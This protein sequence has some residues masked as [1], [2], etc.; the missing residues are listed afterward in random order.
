MQNLILINYL[1][2]NIDRRHDII[3][4]KKNRMLAI[5]VLYGYGSRKEL[6]EAGADIIVENMQELHKVFDKG[7]FYG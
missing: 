6:Q 2:V 5:G 1:V 3:G 7:G 4:A